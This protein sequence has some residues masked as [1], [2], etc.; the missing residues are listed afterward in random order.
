MYQYAYTLN[1]GHLLIF[2]SIDIRPVLTFLTNIPDPW[3]NNGTLGIQWSYNEE[4]SSSCR[5]LTPSLLREEYCVSNRV[6]F[7][8]LPDGRYTLYVE[9]Q[10][11]AGNTVQDSVQ[12]IVGKH[13]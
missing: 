9:G 12:W 6:R 2:L 1:I 10:D 8:N 13:W 4:T 5:L 11:Q 7:T 3:Y